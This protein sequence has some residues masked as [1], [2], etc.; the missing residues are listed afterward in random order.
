MGGKSFLWYGVQCTGTFVFEILSVF[1]KN[2]IKPY[3]LRLG[4]DARIA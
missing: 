4:T 1:S 3:K 2:I